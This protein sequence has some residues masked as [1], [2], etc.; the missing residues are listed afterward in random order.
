MI[1]V[2]YGYS[3]LRIFRIE[4]SSCS[5]V[6]FAGSVLTGFPQDFPQ[7]LLTNDYFCVA[8]YP[9]NTAGD[10]MWGASLPSKTLREVSPQGYEVQDYTWIVLRNSGLHL[11]HLQK[12]AV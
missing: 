10:S 12:T 11:A 4:F 9:L 5:Q 2:L 1:D 8:T 6:V 7:A 3:F